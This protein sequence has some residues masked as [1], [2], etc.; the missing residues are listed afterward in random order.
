M[1]QL[2]PDVATGTLSVSGRA[3]NSTKN[4]AVPAQYAFAVVQV[5]INDFQTDAK[6]GDPDLAMCKTSHGI[7]KT[8]EVYNFVVQGGTNFSLFPVSI[9]AIGGATVPFLVTLR[10]TALLHRRPA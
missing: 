3:D 1:S 9:S 7:L 6:D 5:A 10:Y 4:Y 8:G 2:F